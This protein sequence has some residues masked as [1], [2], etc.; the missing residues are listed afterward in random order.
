MALKEELQQ[1]GNT[2]FK[3][4]GILPLI[5]ILPA[6]ALAIHHDMEAVAPAGSFWETA[7]PFV[8]LLVTLLGLFI[9]IYTVGHTPANTSGRNTEEQVAD[10]VNTTGIYSIVRH[11]LYV[12]NFLM[13][14]GVAMLTYH[15]WFVAV[16]VLLYWIYYERIMFAEEQFLTAKFHEKYLQW[17]AKTPA[18]LPDLRLWQPPALPFSYKKVLKKEK[19]SVLYIF[20]VFFLFIT[21]PHL[22]QQSG[23]V[24]ADWFWVTGLVLSI[25]FYFLIKMLRSRTSLLDEQG[26]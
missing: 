24:P 17:A 2:L 12:G 13:W 6:W 9:R 25:V 22:L 19:N 4:R 15:F 8:C 21:V 20:I 5:I 23:L 26:R 16:F 1:Q 10:V 11:P 3:Y 14:L 18:F 7:Y